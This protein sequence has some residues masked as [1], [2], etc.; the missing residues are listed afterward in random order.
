[1]S[2]LSI[3]DVARQ[4]GVRPSALR[5]YEQVGLIA[6][7]L[8]ESGQR[9]YARSVFDRLSVIAYGKAVG[10]TIAELKLLLSGAASSRA[11]D[12]W[13]ALAERKR[14][15][16]DEVIGRANRMKRL[17][18]GAMKCRCLDLDECGRRLRARTS[19]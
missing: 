11:S 9:R 18:D 12:R 2:G 4:A 14:R 10:F 7:Q 8:R 13:H 3:G 5:Y 16:L 1:V 19:R 15:E 6:P 17:L